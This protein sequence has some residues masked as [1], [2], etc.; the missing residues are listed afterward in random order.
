[1]V[2]SFE[3][4]PGAQVRVAVQV[5][6]EPPAQMWLV[7]RQPDD[8]PQRW[9][10]KLGGRSV[11]QPVPDAPDVVVALSV[12]PEP[13]AALLRSPEFLDVALDLVALN[14]PTSATFDLQPDGLG[15]DSLLTPRVDPDAL[16]T[17][18]RRM[19]ALGWAP[20]QPD[21]DARASPPAQQPET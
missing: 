6:A 5:A 16:W 1:V 13:A 21:E 9:L 17:V 11:V 8:F 20:T 14:A 3:A 2:F 10:D 4:A 18:A 12:D 19:L 15:W 7:G